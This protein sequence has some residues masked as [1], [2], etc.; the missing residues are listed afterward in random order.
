MIFLPF[1]ESGKVLQITKS[2]ISLQTKSSLFGVC[3]SGSPFPILWNWTATLE[4]AGSTSSG[5]AWLGTI[6]GR[7]T[8]GESWFD[9][10]EGSDNLLCSIPLFLGDDEMPEVAVSLLPRFQLLNITNNLP[11]LYWSS[12]F[13]WPRNFWRASSESSSSSSILSLVT[14]DY[15]IQSC[16]Y[17]VV[18]TT[19]YQLTVRIGK[20]SSLNAPGVHI[21]A[22]TLIG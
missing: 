4:P 13:H 6:D 16:C 18:S 15:S 8:D 5:G 14:R 12:S 20:A 10:E 7:F 17:Q 21:L 1:Q 19:L 9:N 22:Q 2:E 11:V 3:S